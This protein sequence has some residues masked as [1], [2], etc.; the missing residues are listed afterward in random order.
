MKSRTGAALKYWPQTVTNPQTVTEF[1][2]AIALNRFRAVR[3][4]IE[5]L[6][7]HPD[8]T[9]ANRPTALCYAVLQRDRC[10]MQ[11]L[12]LKGADINKSDQKGM[13]P[14]HYATLSG[15]RFCVL[16][17]LQSGADVNQENLAGKTP[18]A[19]C[20]DRTDLLAIQILLRRYGAGLTKSVKSNC[21][22]H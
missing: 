8:E 6:G 21:D 10:L 19:L 1:L 20:A 13:A 7:L 22:I 15:C 9:T 16:Y 14:I 11:Y 3:F 4:Y 12:L 5:E 18:F 2:V 17:L